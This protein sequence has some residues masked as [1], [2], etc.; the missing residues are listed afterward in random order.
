[1]HGSPRAHAGMR[2]GLLGG[3]FDP[4][5]AGHAHVART[6]LARLDLDAVWWLV[7]PQNP[8]KAQSSPL[9]ARMASARQVARGRRM[10]VTDLET[11][12][13]TAY[14]I[15][16]ITALKKRYHGVHFVWLMGGD[17]LTGFQR[18]RGWDDIARAV[19]ICVVSRPGGRSGVRMGKLA[20]RF[21]IGRMR[22][23]QALLLPVTAAP[24]WAYISAR[25]N[26]E[27]STRLRREGKGLV[28]HQVGTEPET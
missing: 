9:P 15:D 27:S 19:P 4:A 7:S 21:A 8:L 5:H 12:L 25:W 24:A 28:S 16:T 18:W 2:I 6:G 10:V 14:T 3:S 11:K 1:M 17:N 20:M 23:E 22:E 26:P 13:G